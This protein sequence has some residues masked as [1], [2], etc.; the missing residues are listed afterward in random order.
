MLSKELMILKE[1][2]NRTL[3][4]L[5]ESNRRQ[6]NSRQEISSLTEQYRSQEIKIEKI[7]ADHKKELENLQKNHKVIYF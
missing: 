4:S 2:K 5:T 1:E 6:L 3:E 7:I